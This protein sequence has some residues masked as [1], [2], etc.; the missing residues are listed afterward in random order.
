MLARE[1]HWYGRKPEGP[2]N[3]LLQVGDL[4]T[5]SHITTACRS[6]GSNSGR[7]V[8]KQLSTALLG[9][10]IFVSKRGIFFKNP[11]FGGI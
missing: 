5:L 10:P 11:T 4:R 1:G 2:E 3:K 9:H 6:R 8:E 7:I